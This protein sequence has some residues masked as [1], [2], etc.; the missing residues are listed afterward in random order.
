MFKRI[1]F[2][3]L[4]FSINA[5]SPQGDKIPPFNLKTIEGKTITEEDLKGKITV[6]NVWATWCHNCLNE[7]EDLNSLAQKYK[8]DD[9][10]LLIAVSDENCE[11]VA[12]FLQRHSFDF[13]QLIDGETFT[14]KTQSRLV[15]TYPQHLV[16]DKDLKIRF[17]S[18]SELSDASEQLSTEIE[19]LR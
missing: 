4:A 7:I 18:S 19:R 1:V 6:V 13:I 12:S 9:E 3:L 14:T 2:F 15:K 17:E 10:V 8:D 16:L 5:C 11:Q